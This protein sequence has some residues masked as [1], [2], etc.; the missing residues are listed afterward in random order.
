MDSEYVR[1]SIVLHFLFPQ[2]QL[3]MQICTTLL[4]NNPLQ[5][6]AI[7]LS[8]L[9]V[10]KMFPLQWICTEVLWKFRSVKWTVDTADLSCQQQICRR[11]KQNRVS[12]RKRERN[13]VNYLT[14]WSPSW[15]SKSQPASKQIFRILW[16]EKGHY[17][18]HKCPAIVF[19]LSKINPVQNHPFL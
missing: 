5:D 3:E 10:A 8:F 11:N 2:Y 6:T 13:K 15:E 19:I 17:R 9:I 7:S 12:E 18:V 14:P 4:R 1:L 16:N